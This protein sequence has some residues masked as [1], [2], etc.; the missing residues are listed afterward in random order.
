MHRKRQRSIDAVQGWRFSKVQI[1]L[2]PLSY[3]RAEMLTH[4][5]LEML[6]RPHGFNQSPMRQAHRA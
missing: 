3:Q 5:A 2:S 1:A 4:H 6:M